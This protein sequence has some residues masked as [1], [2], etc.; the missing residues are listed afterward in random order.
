MSNRT[1]KDLTG[2][3]KRAE[4][5]AHIVELMSDVPT[6]A[7]E[8]EFKPTF[9]AITAKLLKLDTTMSKAST[10]LDKK[11]ETANKLR[12]TDRKRNEKREDKK[13]RD[14]AGLEKLITQQAKLQKRIDAAMSV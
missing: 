6:I 3:T 14:R 13:A 9:D 2:E 1:Y 11:I 8:K 12:A 10:S 5:F 4:K 7:G